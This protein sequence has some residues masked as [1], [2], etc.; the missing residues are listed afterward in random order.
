MSQVSSDASSRS[1]ERM[2]NGNSATISVAFLWIQSKSL[3]NSQVLRGKG[4][5]H[6]CKANDIDVKKSKS[7]TKMWKTTLQI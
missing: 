6:L 2:S 7:E 1:T 4:L 3:G 5:I